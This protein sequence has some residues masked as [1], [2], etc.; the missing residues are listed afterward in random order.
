MKSLIGPAVVALR[1][2]TVILLAS[3]AP[4]RESDDSGFPKRSNP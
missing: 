3:P 2:G 1:L 4:V